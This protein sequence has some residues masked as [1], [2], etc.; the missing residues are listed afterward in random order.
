MKHQ[1]KQILQ[2]IVW[3]SLLA[4]LTTT[5]R[6][7]TSQSTSGQSNGEAS[8]KNSV[9]GDARNKQQSVGRLLVMTIVGDMESESF[10]RFNRSIESYKLDLSVIERRQESELS[11]LRKALKTHRSETDLLLMIVDSYNTILNGGQDEIV[12]RFS[13]FGPQSRVIFAADSV[14][15]P[16]ASLAKEFPGPVSGGGGDKYLNSGAFLGFAP[17]IWDLVNY[18]DNSTTTS[19]NT[20]QMGF[21]RAY[22]N[23]TSRQMMGL[24]LDHRAELFQNLRTN[25][26]DLVRVE[27]EP[28][29][30][31][32]KNQ[33]HNTEPVVAVGNKDTRIVLNSLGNYLARAWT[34]RDG[35]QHCDKGDK[36]TALPETVQQLE[37]VPMVV[38]GV[39]IE[40][41]TPFL[42]NFF[43]TLLNLNY[44]A[45]RIHLLVHNSVSIH[46]PIVGRFLAEHGSRYASQQVVEPSEPEWRA[47]E[48]GLRRCQQLACDYYLALDSVAR[49]ELPDTLHILIGANKT[50]VAPLLHR[51]TKLWSNFWGSMSADG[52]YA[53]SHDYVEL[54]K[55]DRVGLWNVPHIMNAYLI[56]GRFIRDNLNNAENHDGVKLT[57]RDDDAT[58]FGARG[59]NEVADKEE[60]EEQE[61]LPL[62]PVLV[63]TK[64]LREANVFQFM[65]NTHE[66]GH[67]VDATNYN[68]SQLHADFYQLE[69]NPLDWERAYLHENY[70]LP[71]EE[72]QFK[73]EQPCP[74]VFWFPL[75]SERFC[76]Q[77]VEI[78]EHFGQWSGGTN[79]DPRIEGGYESVPTRDIHMK[80]VGLHEMWLTFLRDYVQ[81]IQLKEYIGYEHE[82]P[83]ANLA[84]VVRYHPAEQA[85]LQPH[86]DSSTYTLNIALNSPGL[87]YD[88][89]GCR[90]LRYN[91]SVTQSRRGWALMHPGRLT[92]YHE[93]LPVTRGTR[94]IMVTFVDP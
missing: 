11:S 66:F 49:L 32:L 16:N 14:C 69:E 53:R 85:S 31:R 78:M 72:P 29:G 24:R 20:M 19:E 75:V 23:E 6:L 34:P 18:E 43:Q 4:T 89:G 39:F 38:V 1:A 84:F 40:Y 52:Y 48:A 88:G 7:T 25:E 94:Y 61:R 76:T 63:F 70:S 57:Y 27:L 68:T 80:Q 65:M 46:E 51:P 45:K 35:C 54:V 59:A 71:L 62:K 9:A 82:P 74:D 60:D 92:H 87:D 37:A 58:V 13:K 64:K 44:P 93:G 3:F 47:R 21:T 12:T 50:I 30:A 41:G 33:A 28:D 22:L 5:T 26:P 8:Q 86:H 79:H 2:Q 77:L 55:R 67:L 56:S 36:L 15:W 83:R 81:P 73:L 90:F 91:C 42:D 17:A 10:K